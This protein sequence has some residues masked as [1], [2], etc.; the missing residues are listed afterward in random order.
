MISTMEKPRPVTADDPVPPPSARAL[1]VA[2][3][4]QLDNLA[5][6]VNQERPE[7]Y[8]YFRVIAAARALDEARET[9]WR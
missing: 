2:I 8:A 9:L 3:L 5:A 7:S 4:H 6:Q 1:V